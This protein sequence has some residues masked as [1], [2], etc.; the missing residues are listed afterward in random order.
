MIGISTDMRYHYWSILDILAATVLVLSLLGAAWR[1]RERSLPW[2][3][4]GVAGVVLAGVLARLLDVR[5]PV[6]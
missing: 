5:A 4:A 3:L 6:V 1:R 2:S